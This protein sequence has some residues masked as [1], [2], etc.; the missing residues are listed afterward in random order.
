MLSAGWSCPARGRTRSWTPRHRYWSVE[1]RQRE[2]FDV[3]TTR[4]SGRWQD[5]ESRNRVSRKR[6]RGR[7][8]S[9]LSAKRPT[10]EY[11][12]SELTAY[13]DRPAPYRPAVPGGGPR[14]KSIADRASSSRSSLLTSPF[15]VRV[16][17]AAGF[18]WPRSRRKPINRENPTVSSPTRST[19]PSPK[20]RS[21][22]LIPESDLD[23]R[24]Q[25]LG[26]CLTPTDLN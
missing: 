5:A 7:S 3:V 18:M 12:E 20:S 6:W 2:M 16:Q 9:G 26:R 15:R 11:R 17:L 21:I 4:R 19:I 24:T 23:R 10:A 13:D 14:S 22:P 1:S 8:T 25:K